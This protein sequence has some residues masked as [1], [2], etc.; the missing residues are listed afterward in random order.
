M[1][2][3]QGKYTNSFYHKSA[4]NIWIKLCIT[5]HT[6]TKRNEP[7]Y[8]HHSCNTVR[9]LTEY[10]KLQTVHFYY[11]GTFGNI[12]KAKHCGVQL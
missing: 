2:T 4:P 5:S 12:Y 10:L 1:K 3:F 11:V 8:K 9:I 6:D 7:I